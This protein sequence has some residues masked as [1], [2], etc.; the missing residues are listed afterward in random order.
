MGAGASREAASKT[1]HRL[2]KK[3]T[4]KKMVGKPESFGRPR[5]R[6]D[7]IKMYLKETRLEVHWIRMA[8]GRSR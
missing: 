7:D 5:R 3:L 1:R 4:K 8:Q 6:W 2:E